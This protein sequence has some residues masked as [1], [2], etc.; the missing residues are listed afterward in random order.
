ML[1]LSIIV[2]TYN[3]EKYLSRTLQLILGLNKKVNCEIIVVDDGSTDGTRCLLDQY[4][5]LSNF[6]VFYNQHSGVSNSRNFGIKKA[7]GDY[8]T[9]IDSDDLINIKAF[10]KMV[11]QTSM[12]DNPDIVA[13][14][15]SVRKENNNR[16][17]NSEVEKN[18]LLLSNLYI[19]NDEFNGEEYISGPVSKFYKKSLLYDNNISFPIEVD[20]GEDLLFNC[21]AILCSKKIL[22]IKDEA[23]YYRQNSD[24]LMNKRDLKM[25]SK[26]EFLL[27]EI[28]NY[29]KKSSLPDEKLY[30]E[31]WAI[32]LEL[33]NI[34]RL[35]CYDSHQ[36]FLEFKTAVR[37]IRK[38]MKNK[39]VS[40]I[41][42]VNLSRRQIQ[43]IQFL[44]FTP[45]MVSIYLVRII[46]QIMQSSK[47][48]NKTLRSI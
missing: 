16:I 31:Y 14:S 23:Y 19:S 21:K 6:Y 36:Y 25:K 42:Y 41:V 17:V 47:R 3:S 24:S 48:H 5:H 11:N 26:N 32:R 2:P 13:C 27:H 45:S 18:K 20:N 8:L 4:Q 29:L 10:E 46:C 39:R 33:T 12:A 1:Y 40:K 7:N 38:I 44:C 28:K 30:F 37:R 9:F 15:K 35:Y 34:I 22:L 43:V